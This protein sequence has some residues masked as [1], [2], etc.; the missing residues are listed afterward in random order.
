VQWRNDPSAA[1]DLPSP[2]SAWERGR[3]SMWLRDQSGR[4]GGRGDVRRRCP[5][6]RFVA[7]VWQSSARSEP[8]LGPRRDHAVVAT[9]IWAGSVAEGRAQFEQQLDLYGGVV[10]LEQ[11]HNLVSWRQH[12]E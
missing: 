8:A 9:K 11:I 7:D 3:H 6:G 2:L 4:D 10:D 1:G 5:A 12:L